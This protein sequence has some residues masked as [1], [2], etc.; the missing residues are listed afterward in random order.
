MS[1]A[2]VLIRPYITEKTNTAKE[3]LNKVVFE[4]HPKSNKIQ[5]Q[6]AIEKLFKVKVKKVATLNCKGKLK[7]QGA[8]QGYRPNYKKAVITLKSGKIEYFEGA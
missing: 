4:V 8:S 5:I 6:Q 3:Q 2:P 7:R 1:Q